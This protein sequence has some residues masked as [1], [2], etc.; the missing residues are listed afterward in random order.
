MHCFS[1]DLFI[2][3]SSIQRQHLVFDGIQSYSW[4]DWGTKRSSD[5]PEVILESSFERRTFLLPRLCAVTGHT[6]LKS[7]SPMM[8]RFSQALI[9]LF[10]ALIVWLILLL[11]QFH[12]FGQTILRNHCSTFKFGSGFPSESC[13][14]AKLWKSHPRHR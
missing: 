12:Q 10:I 5:L 3:H 7:T 9:I 8:R 4:T 6:F 11:Y 1:C 14:R 13:T 2:Q